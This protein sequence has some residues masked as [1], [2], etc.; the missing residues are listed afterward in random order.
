M[1]E[2]HGVEAP[3]EWLA[4]WASC[5]PWLQ[6]DLVKSEPFTEPCWSKDGVWELKIL[7]PCL[8]DRLALP[9]S[10]QGL[11][12]NTVRSSKEDDGGT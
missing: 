12:R 1:S 3:L 6:K 5:R 9:Q 2:D 8:F 10:N 7:A 4:W 11:Q